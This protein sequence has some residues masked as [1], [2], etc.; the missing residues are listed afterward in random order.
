MST[1]SSSPEP[2]NAS[3]PQTPSPASVFLPT[4]SVIISEVSQTDIH[5]QDS[6]D[7]FQSAIENFADDTSTS[8]AKHSRKPF[9]KKSIPSTKPPNTEPVL[10]PASRKHTSISLLSSDEELNHL[11]EIYHQIAQKLGITNKLKSSMHKRVLEKFNEFLLGQGKNT[12]TQ[13]QLQNFVSNK[14]RSYS[15]AKKIM[16]LTGVEYSVKNKRLNTTVSELKTLCSRLDQIS[17]NDQL[18]ACKK[19]P[20]FNSFRK[21]DQATGDCLFENIEVD[22]DILVKVSGRVTRNRS[23]L[24]NLPFYS[25]A[26]DSIPTTRQK[27]LGPDSNDPESSPDEPKDKISSENKSILERILL[28]V[29]QTDRQVIINSLM[30]ED[31][32]QQINNALQYYSEKYEDDFI[33][34]LKFL[35]YTKFNSGDNTLHPI[36]LPTKNVNELESDELN[37]KPLKFIEYLEVRDQSDA[38]ESLQNAT[39]SPLPKV[40]ISVKQ[41]P[42]STILKS[43]TEKKVDSSESQVKASDSGPVG[44]A[45]KSTHEKHSTKSLSSEHKEHSTKSLSPEHKRHAKLFRKKNKIRSKKKEKS[46]GTTNSPVTIMK[47]SDD[48]KVTK[49]SLDPLSTPLNK[50]TK[51]APCKMSN[52]KT[53][54]SATKSPDSNDTKTW[55]KIETKTSHAKKVSFSNAKDIIKTTRKSTDFDTFASIDKSKPHVNIQLYEMNK[56]TTKKLAT[57]GKSKSRKPSK[58]KRFLDELD[59]NKKSKVP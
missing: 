3:N 54:D 46:Q 37:E 14:K 42:F 17:G 59:A 16:T 49:V 9:D 6:T 24:Q 18:M 31:F 32:S 57:Y 26:I 35:A 36:I 41:L 15:A 12:I 19:I 45:K 27:T 23:N 13:N 44:N 29:S 39:E 28:S 20:Y 10:V 33:D 56:H 55:T 38:N 43:N 50:V 4:P 47:R 25:P 51:Q 58:R 2:K 5:G 53:I 34:N 1:N 22:G 8:K 7:E 11:L 30:H 21:I 40:D 52:E 48:Y